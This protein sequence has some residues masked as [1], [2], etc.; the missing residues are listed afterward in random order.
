MRA[1][2][3]L[4]SVWLPINVSPTYHGLFYGILVIAALAAGSFI[5]LRWASSRSYG[6]F[7]NVLFGGMLAR[8]AIVGGLM[9]WVWR[10]ST[11]DAMAFTVTVLAGYVV[12]QAVE[13][14]V[15]QKQVRSA[16]PAGK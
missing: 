1:G 9:V 10:F 5:A 11:I 13:V 16:R 15:A 4:L 8:L 2:Q 6:T 12:F 7:L 3:C 14:F